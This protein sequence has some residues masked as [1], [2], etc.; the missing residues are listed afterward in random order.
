MS[1]K[2]DHLSVKVGESKVASAA[3]AL[4]LFIDK[5]E[6][7]ISGAILPQLREIANELHNQAVW[8]VFD[9]SVH[10][11]MMKQATVIAERAFLHKGVP[12]AIHPRQ[13]EALDSVIKSVTHLGHYYDKKSGHKDLGDTRVF[14]VENFKKAAEK[15]SRYEQND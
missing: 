5:N 12:L 9:L 8:V 7:N 6:R 2:P 14:N 11:A 10:W 1:D 15:L 4:L 3:E 13:K